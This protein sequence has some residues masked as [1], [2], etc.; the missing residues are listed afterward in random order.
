MYLKI[1]ILY[2]ISYKS[3]FLIVV[4]S[5]VLFKA[6]NFLINFVKYALVLSTITIFQKRF[7]TRGTLKSLRISRLAKIPT[8]YRNHRLRSLNEEKGLLF[9][10][11]RK[12]GGFERHSLY[13]TKLRII[14]WS[15]LKY[16]FLS[17]CS[18]YIVYYVL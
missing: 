7:Y 5:F 4:V 16:I 15:I 14:F 12:E 2:C 13:C 10:L 17:L 11:H 9:E 8:L 1:I 6:Y 3:R 18:N